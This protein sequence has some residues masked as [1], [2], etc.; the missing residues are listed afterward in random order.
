MEN[1]GRDA[2]FV[3]VRAHRPVVSFKPSA[4]SLEEE[5]A[6][7]PGGTPVAQDSDGTRRYLSRNHTLFEVLL[8]T[9]KQAPIRS[10]DPVRRQYR[11]LTSQ[12]LSEDVID[13]LQD[14]VYLLLQ[15]L[16][17]WR[18][19]QTPLQLGRD[20]FLAERVPLDRR[21]GPSTLNQV[22][23][24]QLTDAG[25]WED[26]LSDLIA[27]GGRLAEQRPMERVRA[28]QMVAEADPR[29]GAA[30]F[31]VIRHGRGSLWHSGL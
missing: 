30:V 4:E 10:G 6:I 13:G 21:R 16:L 3:P 29:V 2:V 31:A 15:V 26:R 9:R 28:F 17:G 11:R 18:E 1:R 27:P 24:V 5:G 25:G 19:L 22:E 12:D 7:L 14:V 23:S 8:E 20:L